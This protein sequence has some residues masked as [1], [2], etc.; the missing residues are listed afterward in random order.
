MPPWMAMAAGASALR[1]AAER[2]RRLVRGLD[3]L[4][5]L[6]PLRQ[7]AKELS[8]KMGEVDLRAVLG[9]DPLDVVGTIL[10]SSANASRPDHD[11]EREP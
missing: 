5:L 2:S 10:R 9:F 11:D 1:A 6:D 3:A 7:R 8:E 4:G